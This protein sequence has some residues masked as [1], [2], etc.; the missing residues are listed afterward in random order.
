M[1]DQGT[2]QQPLHVAIVGS[3]PS[4]FYAAEALLRSGRDVRVNMIER[5]PT[6]YGLVR[7]GVA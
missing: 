5:L 1:A 4:G 2:V 6:P 3:G 7:S